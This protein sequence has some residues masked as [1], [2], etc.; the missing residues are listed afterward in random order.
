MSSRRRPLTLLALAIA[1]FAYLFFFAGLSRDELKRAVVILVLFR[2]VFQ[3][4]KP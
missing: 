1:Y 3:Q 2:R 4:G